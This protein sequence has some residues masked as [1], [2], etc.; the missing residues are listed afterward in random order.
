MNS[1]NKVLITFIF[2]IAVV[3][4]GTWKFIQSERFGEFLSKELTK[5]TKRKIGINVSFRNLKL[6]VIPLGTKFENIEITSTNRRINLQAKEVNVT[7]GF[8]DLLSN[9]LSIE[10]FM[11]ES[12]FIKYRHSE[13]V[14]EV[15]N[16]KI[17]FEKIFNQV[18]NLTLKNEKIRLKSVTFNNITFYEN[19]FGFAKLT[20]FET[21]AYNNVILLEGSL[22][23]SNVI[24]NL[25]FSNRDH[26]KHDEIS[27]Q[28]ELT[29]KKLRVKKLE[30]RESVNR[31]NMSGVVSSN[32]DGELVTVSTL[33][34]EGGMA[35]FGEPL[36]IPLDG[37]CRLTSTINGKV[38]K[39]SFNASVELQDF[40]S[41]WAIADTANIDVSLKDEK[42]TLNQMKVNR[43]S[44][45]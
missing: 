19:S 22:N 41:P 6:N 45:T 39:P 2:F 17:D 37:F 13:N 35:K 3:F 8:F 31:V 21:R 10:N 24:E 11:V 15:S 9:K 18:Q 34:Y 1:I 26:F 30:V 23:A 16:T 12:G 32:S 25:P 20:Q 14:E 4:G 29:K 28:M 44:H 33:V 36:G 5:F 40:N 43:N 7:F 42:L 27:V 38:T